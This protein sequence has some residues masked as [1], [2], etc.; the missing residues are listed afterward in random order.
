MSQII[1]PDYPAKTPYL[2]LMLDYDGTLAPIAS[3]PEDAVP[4][5]EMLLLLKRLAQVPT[6]RLA[7]VSGRSISQLKTFLGE[8]LANSMYLCGL[9]GGEIRQ[10]PEDL[11]LRSPSV[12]VRQHISCFKDQLITILRIKELLEFVLLEDKIFS[13]ALHYRLTPVEKKEAAS[14]CFELLFR[15]S[16]SLQGQFRIQPGKEVLELLPAT[17]DKGSC[18]HFLAQRWQQSMPDQKFSYTYVGDDLTDEQ[19][20]AAVRQLEGNAILVGPPRSG[21]NASAG[22]GSTE[23]LYHSLE[24]LLSEVEQ[25]SQS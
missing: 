9:H 21:S 1:A 20:F 11:S 3:R 18:V 12:L 6:I 7:I 14:Q 2:G 16:D 4:T 10:Y 17:F 5:R 13:L 24:S 19:A 8:T 15:S 25:V 22:I 23:L